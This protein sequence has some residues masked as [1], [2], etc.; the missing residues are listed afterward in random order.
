MII[1]YI[2]LQRAPLTA[3]FWRCSNDGCSDRIK[4]TDND[5]FIE[6]RNHGHYHLKCHEE[7]KVR[8]IVTT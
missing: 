2:Y 3:E 4:T 8:Q 5:V 1:F 7:I 6:Y